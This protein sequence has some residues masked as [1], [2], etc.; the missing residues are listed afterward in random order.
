MSAFQ[1]FGQTQQRKSIHHN[2][3]DNLEH[4]ELLMAAPPVGAVQ[5][6]ATRANSQSLRRFQ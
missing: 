5:R 4:V 3:T 6:K 1:I 2:G